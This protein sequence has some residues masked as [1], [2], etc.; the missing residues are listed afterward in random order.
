MNLPSN[1]LLNEKRH[2]DSSGKPEESLVGHLSKASAY[3]FPGLEISGR[4]A[5]LIGA[6]QKL[7]KT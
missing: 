2:L 3:Q 5:N 4:N 1:S 6:K 7:M